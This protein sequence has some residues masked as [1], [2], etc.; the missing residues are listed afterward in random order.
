MKLLAAFLLLVA[1]VVPSP[2]LRYFRYQ[3]SVQL[4]PD[5]AGQ[6]CAVLDPGVFAQA[7]PG[8][9]DVRLYRDGSE[10]P[11]MVHSFQAPA[12]APQSIPATVL[13][14]RAVGRTV[15]DA[16]MPDGEYMTSG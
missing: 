5:A 16:T 4:P 15:S 13:R 2:E 1:A 7:S 10:A 11:Y 8:L 14:Q 12:T 3:R 6:V 9:A